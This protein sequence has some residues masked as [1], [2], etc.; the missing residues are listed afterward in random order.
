ME[1]VYALSADY[2]KSFA[3]PLKTLSFTPVLQPVYDHV[4]AEFGR[5]NYVNAAGK[6]YL[7]WYDTDIELMVLT[8]G[9]RTTRF[10]ADFSRN[11]SV[12]WEIHGEIAYIKDVQNSLLDPSG[13]VS[14]VEYDA[15]SYLLGIRYLTARDTTFILEYYRNGAG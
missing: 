4:N 12:N 2:T 3:G 11:L 13:R 10:G 8:G 9:S 6:L 15:T 14:T 1:G 5:K 7:L